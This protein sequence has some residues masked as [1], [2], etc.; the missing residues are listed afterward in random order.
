M[1]N[2]II[3]HTGKIN[4]IY[5]N[6]NDCIIEILSKIKFSKSEI[7]SSVSCSGTCL[8]LEK[9]RKNVELGN[10][11]RIQLMGIAITD[12]KS[13]LEFLQYFIKLCFQ[14]MGITV[15]LSHLAPGRNSPILAIAP[16]CNSRLAPGRNSYNYLLHLHNILIVCRP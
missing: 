16:C 1:F 3:K 11:D 14:R 2:G 10:S 4:K 9:Y 13:E 12:Y 7:G 8:T 15:S 6:N 5:K